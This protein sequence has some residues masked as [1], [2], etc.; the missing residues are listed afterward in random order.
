MITYTCA[1]KHL[2]GMNNPSATATSPQHHCLECRKGLCGSP[3]GELI[4]ELPL[5][6]TIPY[7]SL[8]ESGKLLY[9]SHSALICTICIGRCRTQVV[10]P[11]KVSAIVI[12]TLLSISI[13]STHIHVCLLASSSPWQGSSS[14][15]NPSCCCFTILVET[16]SKTSQE[17]Q[18]WEVVLSLYHHPSFWWWSFYCLSELWRV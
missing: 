8:C 9:K 13:Y 16:S 4:G 11:T 14:I 15:H 7:D 17:A 18:G 12:A 2:C 1:A 10:L 5:D 6:I 3:C